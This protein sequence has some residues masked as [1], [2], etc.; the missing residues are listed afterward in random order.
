MPSAIKLRAKGH[1]NLYTQSNSV[2]TKSSALLFAVFLT[3]SQCNGC[4]I[5]SHTSHL[6]R[7][8]V[9][10]AHTHRVAVCLSTDEI[11]EYLIKR[12]TTW[13]D[14]KGYIRRFIGDL[15]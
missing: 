3:T 2:S 1:M 9:F 13:C 7:R 12:D 11:P 6:T 15:N 4:D 14:I 5:T 10:G 8:H